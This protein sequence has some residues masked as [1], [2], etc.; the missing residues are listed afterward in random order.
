MKLAMIAPIPHLKEYA[1]VYK[2]KYHLILS[3]LCFTDP[4]Y[5]KFYIK[6]KSQDPRHFIILDNGA[7]EGEMIKGFDLVNLGTEIG[8][9]EII[10]PDKYAE[11]ELTITET[12]SFIDTWYSVC[13]KAGIKIM[14]VPQGNTK[15]E[16]LRCYKE[17][18]DNPNISTIGLGYKNLIH[19]FMYEIAGITE[20][21]WKNWKIKEIVDLINSLEENTFYYTLSRIYFLKKY[22]NFKEL[23]RRR[24]KIHLLG[25]YNPYELSFYGRFFNKKELSRIRG[26]DS[27][28]PFQAA[29]MDIEFN[30]NYGVVMKPKAFL[31]FNQK[32]IG[33]SEAILVNNIKLIKK[34]NKE[35]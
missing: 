22:V 25:L 6:L 35:K 5:K 23:E 15:E 30:H 2:S 8:V 11:A 29:Q 3:H 31:D 20:Q 10:A 34:W 17:F 13:K 18:I 21:Q 12:N 14:G 26:C 32:L 19:S 16:F 7:N 4:S 1:D 24:K 28:A 9:D 33:E 27:A